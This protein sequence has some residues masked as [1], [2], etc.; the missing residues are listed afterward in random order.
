MSTSKVEYLVAIFFQ[1]SYSLV[2]KIEIGQKF[3]KTAIVFG[4][5][6]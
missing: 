6:I 2:P 5:I 3:S 4:Q 1:I